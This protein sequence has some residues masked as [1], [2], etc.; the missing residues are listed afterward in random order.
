MEAWFSEV[1][2]LKLVWW[3][4]VKGKIESRMLSCRTNYAAYLVFKL[5]G[6]RCEFSERCVAL[7][8]KVEAFALGEGRS[9]NLDPPENEAQ[10]A[11]E[12]GD[13]WME[14]EMGEFLE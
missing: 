1:A 10:Q 7:R 2:E 9:V 14:I 13:G 6:N 11:Q 12:R 5:N 8:V 4:D 3:L